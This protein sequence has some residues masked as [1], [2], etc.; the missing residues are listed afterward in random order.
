MTAS[1]RTWTPYGNEAYRVAYMRRRRIL[2]VLFFLAVVG[3]LFAFIATSIE[4]QTSLSTVGGGDSVAIPRAPQQNGTAQQGGGPVTVEIRP[5]RVT[6]ARSFEGSNLEQTSTR[7]GPRP[8]TDAMPF[9]GRVNLR[10]FLIL[11]AILFGLGSLA[12]ALASRKTSAM[13]EV[14]FGVYK[15]AMPPELIL[16][17]AKKHV[18]T[19]KKVERPL[20]GR[21]AEDF[22]PPEIVRGATP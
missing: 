19:S 5:G 12:R 6:I 13:E 17:V 10:P 1:P 15:G 16:R 3:L 4:R 20:F 9:H 7:S 2:A 21:R 14:N 18:V 22:V 8:P 11:A